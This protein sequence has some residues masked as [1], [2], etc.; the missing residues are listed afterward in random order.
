MLVHG[1]VDAALWGNKAAFLP[2]LLLALIC[3]LYLDRS[4]DRAHFAWDQD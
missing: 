4:H 3:L 2:W 1:L